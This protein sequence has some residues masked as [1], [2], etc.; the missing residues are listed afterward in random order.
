MTGEII[1]IKK[2]EKSSHGNKYL[3]VEFKMSNGQYA[4]TYLCRDYRNWAHWKGLLKIG[5]VLTRL[6]MSGDYLV[7]ADS[8][9]MLAQPRGLNKMELQDM[10]KMG[11]FG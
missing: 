11:I 2:S 7:N 4:K 3:M 10:F 5:N 6:N 8:W 9:P 1:N